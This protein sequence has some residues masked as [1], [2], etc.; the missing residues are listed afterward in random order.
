MALTLLI[1]VDANKGARLGVVCTI[2]ESIKEQ[3]VVMVCC[4][5]WLLV[6][7]DVVAVIINV[8]EAEITTR[9]LEELCKLVAAV[10]GIVVAEELVGFVLAAAVA[11]GIIG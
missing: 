10:A 3:V 4:C 5:C 9:V 7:T 11:K 6:V 1:V 8:V 2:V